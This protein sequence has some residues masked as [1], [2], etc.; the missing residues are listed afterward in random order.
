V[1]KT[2]LKTLEVK[3]AAA[4]KGRATRVERGTMGKRQGK[5]IKAG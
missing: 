1:K 3:A 5:K 4:D 2:G